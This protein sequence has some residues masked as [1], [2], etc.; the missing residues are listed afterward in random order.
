MMVKIILSAAFQGYFEQSAMGYALCKGGI[1]HHSVGC[2]HVAEALARKTQCEDPAKAYTAGLLHDI[3]KVVLDQFVASA[4]PLFYREIMD[5]EEDILSIEAHVLKVKHT[6]VGA[7]LA[8]QWSL[9][10]PL[11]QVIQHHHQPH[12][13]SEDNALCVTVYLADL[14][15]SRFNTGLEIERLDTRALAGLLPSIGL[16]SG[17]FAALVDAIPPS[18]L[19]PAEAA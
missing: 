18:V 11:T 7:L 5:T 14:L 10:E 15:M 1:Y 17:D 3:G 2:A 16:K 6:D 9:P 4:R 13:G 12:Q 19:K 8:R